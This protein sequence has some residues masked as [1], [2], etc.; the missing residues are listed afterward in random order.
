MKLCYLYFLFVLFIITLPVY[1]Q[2]NLNTYQQV[3]SIDNLKIDSTKKIYL[4]NCLKEKAEHNR[5]TTDS[6]YAFVLIKLANY[7]S[8][9]NNNLS[10]AINYASEALQILNFS[11]ANTNKYLR[12]NAC[13]NLAIFYYTSKLYNKS[14]HYFDTVILLGKKYNID[15][16]L[17][18]SRLYR[19]V[20]D[21]Y[22]GDYGKVLDESYLGM[23]E[24]LSKEDTFYYALFL[25]LN[26]RSLTMQDQLP[27]ALTNIE[28]LIDVAQKS[29]DNY[30][31]ANAYNLKAGIYKQKEEYTKAEY[32]Y[33][34]AIQAR[35][36][37]K[38]KPKEI[39]TDYNDLAILYQANLLD[40]KKAEENFD[41]TIYYGNKCLPEDRS[42]ILLLGTSNLGSGLVRQNLPLQAIKLYTKA[43]N[44]VNIET[45]NFLYFN[46][47]LKQL[48]AIGEKDIILSILFSK[49]ELLLNLSKD[50]KNQ[51]YLQACIATAIVTDS[52]ITQMRHEQLGDKSKLYWRNKTRDF[53]SETMEACYL[54]GNTDMAFYFMERSRS[55]L[56]SD[57]LNDLRSTVN[58]LPFDKVEKENK[59]QNQITGIEKK[60]SG[61]QPASSLY[62]VTQNNLNQTREEWRYF[63][64]YLE[65]NY[66][67]YYQYKYDDNVPS[68]TSLQQ[69]LAK[70]NQ[71]FVYYFMNDSA[72][73]AL[74][75][76]KNKTK[77][78]KISTAD[79]DKQQLTEYIRLC[80]NKEELNRHY[81]QYAF[82][83]Q[84]IY[85]K[86]FK[87]LQI[88]GGNVAICTDNFFIPFE[89]LCTNDKGTNYLLYKYNFSYV[90]SAR[91]LIKPF[92][93]N[94]NP[95][96]N[97][98]GFAP[99]SFASSLGVADLKTSAEALQ[100]SAKFYSN[101]TLFT[102][103][104]ATHDGFLKQA[105]H[106]S[107][108]TIF[109]HAQADTTDA[110]PA[111]YMKDSIIHLSELQLLKNPSIQF[112]LLS[113]C[114]TNI[115][116]NATGEGI[117]SLARGFAAAGIPAVS[118]TL[119]KAD[120]GAIYKISGKFNEYLARGMNKSEALQKAK[121]WYLQSTEN[122][123][124]SLPFYWANMVLIG[125]SQ[126]L[127]LTSSNHNWLYISGAVLSA[128]LLVLV[129]FFYKKKTTKT[130][131]K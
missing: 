111:L 86:L 44:Y 34:L 28:A 11:L 90:Y 47:P 88:N 119:W 108:V 60:L 42:V 81:K 59:L 46:P 70:N 17:V 110:E 120:E 56:L 102:Q 6:G 37:V 113:A 92:I 96:G 89:A 69:Y 27:K 100:N 98:A 66:P 40:Y 38:N 80:S 95:T 106:Y 7:E 2:T 12:L 14:A 31:L 127:V 25:Y 103:Q 43:L 39:A 107:V 24:A 9:K 72:I 5:E 23:Q 65:N 115:G 112:V 35:L 26:A 36:L 128:L 32:F 114:Q 109:S 68:L 82:L 58:Y 50:F 101:N 97:F 41:K 131:Y 74:A 84:H 71:H 124:K 94:T 57:K 125:S 51:R 79:F 4:L 105:S 129:F 63:I 73:Y 15:S 62:S 126:P 54:S 49:C 67:L 13:K 76:S 3:I 83:A 8:E 29:H 22:L 53:F 48:S 85:Q 78:I 21:D 87:P 91:S 117:Y 118:A 33:K 99:V 121:I 116:K 20:I 104:Q 1:C 10:L 55:V 122:S 93:S 19:T 61:L 52:L 77:F 123:E 64:K 30:L 75:V 16:F 130:H 18:F 45:N